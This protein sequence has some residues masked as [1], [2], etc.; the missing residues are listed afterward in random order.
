MTNNVV[1]SPSAWGEIRIWIAPLVVVDPWWTF[2][3]VCI[4]LG[5]VLEIQRSDFLLVFKFALFVISA[6]IPVILHQTIRRVWT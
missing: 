5:R 6:V 2:L 1:F 4:R 3:G